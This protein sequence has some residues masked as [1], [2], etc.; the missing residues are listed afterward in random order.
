[1]NEQ[2]SKSEI[3]SILLELAIYLDKLCKTEQIDYLIFYGTLLGAVRHSGFIPWDDDIDIVMFEED[4]TQLIDV[5][6]NYPHPHIKLLCAKTNKKYQDWVV[7]LVDTRTVVQESLTGQQTSNTGLLDEPLGLA[8][9]IYPLLGGFN[10]KIFQKMLAA[11]Y[12]IDFK[13][14]S[15]FPKFKIIYYMAE[16]LRKCSAKSSY[17]TRADY[18]LTYKQ[19]EL[20]PSNKTVFENH[21]FHAPSDPHALLTKRYGDYMTL[22]NED[23]IAKWL[24]YETVY[25]KN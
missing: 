7:R 25:W 23:E 19:S 17:F 21:I 20:L 18:R 16:L 5:F 24:H 12:V 1:M 11:L 3:R 6:E 2:L 15:S 13:C 14:R 22:P 4:V 10:N 8:L 9:D